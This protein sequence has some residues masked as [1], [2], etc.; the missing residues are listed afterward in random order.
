MT[1]E[2]R[3]TL[4]TDNMALIYKAVDYYGKNMLSMDNPVISREDMIQ[5]CVLTLLKCADSYDPA[6]GR[7]ST[8]VYACVNFTLKTYYRKNLKN[9]PKQVEL[10]KERAIEIEDMAYTGSFND[11]LLMDSLCETMDKIE[12]A[13]KNC[14]LYKVAKKVTKLRAAGYVTDDI[15]TM[16]NIT[17]N[18]LK[19]IDNVKRRLHNQNREAFSWIYD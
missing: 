18:D 16:L 11:L 3:N 2:E 4:I 17:R 19:S 14:A 7:F 15:C 13:H 1:N 8:F 12:N 6:H 9:V 10:E 5:E